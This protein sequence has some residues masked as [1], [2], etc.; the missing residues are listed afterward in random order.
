M[1]SDSGTQHRQRGFGAMQF[2][3]GVAVTG[4]RGRG[5][6]EAPS[7]LFIGGQGG[8][9]AP[10]QQCL[11]ETRTARVCRGQQAQS[12]QSGTALPEG[13]LAPQPG[14]AKPEGLQ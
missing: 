11:G 8:V 2:Q 14:E 7:R 12:D 13:R 5:L 10:A 6:R 9:L 4:Q 1:G 3:Q